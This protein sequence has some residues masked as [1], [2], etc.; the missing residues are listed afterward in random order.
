VSL[1]LRLTSLLVVI[2]VPLAA[3]DFQKTVLVDLQDYPELSIRSI[4]SDPDGNLF[5]YDHRSIYIVSDGELTPFVQ[6][7]QGFIGSICATARSLIISSDAATFLYDREQKK[8]EEILGMRAIQ[9]CAYDRDHSYFTAADGLYSSPRYSR[10]IPRRRTTAFADHKLCEWRGRAYLAG[11]QGLHEIIAPDDIIPLRAD[12]V[13]QLIPS[14]RGLLLYHDRTL[15]L[16]NGTSTHTLTD[17]LD[18]IDMV[19]IDDYLLATTADTRYLLDL[20]AREVKLR[21]TADLDV[22]TGNI[23]VVY[24]HDLTATAGSDISVWKAA[25]E[26]LSGLQ[27]GDSLLYLADRYVLYRRSGGAAY[28]LDMPGMDRLVEVPDDLTAIAGSE[29]DLYVASRDLGILHLHSDESRRFSPPSKGRIHALSHTD[30]GLLISTDSAVSLLDWRDTIS[31]Q[32]KAINIHHVEQRQG[33]LYDRTGD[34][35][36]II[37]G[38]GLLT[39]GTDISRLYCEC[40]DELYHVRGEQLVS[41]STSI[42]LPTTPGSIVN[43]LC[44][45]EGVLLHG[46]DSLWHMSDGA[47]TSL[48]SLSTET[49]LYALPQSSDLLMRNGRYVRRIHIPSLLLDRRPRLTLSSGDAEIQRV[50]YSDYSVQCAEYCKIIV[51]PSA[52][53]TDGRHQLRHRVKGGA[54]NSWTYGDQIALTAAELTAGVDIQLKTS[55]GNT[56]S[57]VSLRPMSSEADELISFSMLLMMAGGLLALLV[58]AIVILRRRAQRVEDDAQSRRRSIQRQRIAELEQK[59]LQLQMN[60]HFIFNS[61]QSIRKQ[62]ALGDPARSDQLITASGKL[63]RSTLDHSRAEKISLEAELEYLQS[64]LDLEKDLRS[65]FTYKITGDEILSESALVMIPPL[66]LQPFVENSIV[67][68]LSSIR[69]DGLLQIHFADREKHILVSI[70][71]NGQGRTAAGADKSSEHISHAMNIISERLS[72]LTESPVRYEDLYDGQGKAAGTRVWVKLPILEP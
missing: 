35:L 37:T 10:E 45:R 33:N 63:M 40:E 24:H 57:I 30:A 56:S 68:G 32:F 20:S 43:I 26:P 50:S 65:G 29:V 2:S 19:V 16:W 8:W 60:P 23:E 48:M 42:N 51:Q 9:G 61:L 15:S 49:E 67:H 21:T 58:I 25:K 7:T 64:Y 66:I 54:W 69:V 31:P 39:L 70:T 38:H 12:P 3:Q 62:V 52:F 6:F 28:L 59:S 22:P 34:T 36:R 11:S 71:D 13:D 1:W 27:S 46:V 44:S 5:A 41:E 14:R 4:V 72:G 18:L 55:D 53:Y 47:F 17:D